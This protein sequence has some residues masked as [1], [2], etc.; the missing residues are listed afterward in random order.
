VLRA[1]AGRGRLGGTRDPSRGTTTRFS[2]RWLGEDCGEFKPSKS[3][4]VGDR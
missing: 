2:I 1:S 4:I 3:E